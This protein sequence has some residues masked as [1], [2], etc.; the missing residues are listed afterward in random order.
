MCHC[1]MA[2]TYT[3]ANEICNFVRDTLCEMKETNPHITL[4][5][6]CFVETLIDIH[7][8]NDYSTYGCS[9]E[10]ILQKIQELFIL[11]L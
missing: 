8:H 11:I 9:H 2:L 6:Q 7:H 1:N 4:T 5:F 3:T 10:L